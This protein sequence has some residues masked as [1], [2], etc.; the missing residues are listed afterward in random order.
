MT[1]VLASGKAKVSPSVENVKK[2]VVTADI[3][4][5]R[6]NVLEVKKKPGF[7]VAV[8]LKL[9]PGWAPI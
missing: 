8:K 9:P 5:P 7:A 2:G 4:V 1:V 6:E 3:L